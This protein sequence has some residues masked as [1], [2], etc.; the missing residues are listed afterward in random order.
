[1]NIQNYMTNIN[2]KMG[3]INGPWG[4][5]GKV[6]KGFW[7]AMGDPAP[8]KSTSMNQSATEVPSSTLHIELTNVSIYRTIASTVKAIGSIIRF[9]TLNIFHHVTDPVDTSWIGSHIDIRSKSMYAQ[10]EK[11]IMDLIEARERRP[12][13]FSGVDSGDA[14]IRPK[15]RLFITGHSLGGALGTSKFHYFILF[16]CN[17]YLIFYSLVFLFS[18]PC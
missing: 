11:H 5:M 4:P 1:M 7:N 8:R 17:V 6:H 9:L 3:A 10:A 16:C 14:S 18:L 2:M 15:S 13:R 12:S